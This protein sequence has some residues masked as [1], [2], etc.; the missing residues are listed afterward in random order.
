MKKIISLFGIISLILGQNIPSQY[1]RV[2]QRKGDTQQ[3]PQSVAMDIPS[4]TIPLEGPINS[5]T[6]IL[7]P[8]DKIG[9][10]IVSTTPMFYTLAVNPAGDL[11]IPTVGK[12][13]VAGSTLNAAIDKIIS[14]I[15]VQYKNSTVHVTLLEIRSFLVSITGAVL[16]PG[17]V[18]VYSIQRLW[19]VIEENAPL[20]PFADDE[21]ILITH[22]DGEVQA[23]SLK[24]YLTDGKIS[25]N[26]V[27]LEGD[28]IFVPF[29][30][31]YDDITR[32]QISAIDAT[33]WVTG[34]VEYPGTYNYI[35]GYDLDHYLGLAGGA[36]KNG[37]EKLAYIQRNGEILKTV[38]LLPGDKIVIP[39]TLKSRLIGDT[40]ILQTLTA[41][42]SLYL[43]Y[44]AA[45]KR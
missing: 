33:V 42:A 31:P 17:D 18:S 10:D 40:S 43:T 26:P 30:Q 2:D 23:V 9:I 27:L 16:K 35:A 7:G 19:T 8:G 13:Q 1:G 41:M 29:R 12:I 34:F 45:T 25:N 36:L 28:R 6:Y 15:T 21:H 3:Q 38:E 44:R 5:D 11:L 24:Q 14:L 4:S 39:E 32:D 37:S 22:R 20:H